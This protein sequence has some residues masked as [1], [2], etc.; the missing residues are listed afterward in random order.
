MFTDKCY[1][2]KRRASS[3][4][5]NATCCTMKS[6]WLG[7][8]GCMGKTHK[9][10][11][12]A[13]APVNLTRGL[14][15]TYICW[16]TFHSATQ[17]CT[18]GTC[19]HI[20]TLEN[21]KIARNHENDND[22]H[23]AHVPTYV[24]GIEPHPSIEAKVTNSLTVAHPCASALC[25]RTPLTSRQSNIEH[26]GQYQNRYARTHNVSAHLCRSNAYLL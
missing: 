1:W 5:P 16:C 23:I 8:P 9:S 7:I 24:P 15:R 13:D 20:H 11:A 22:V 4:L 6:V 25:R 3:V 2:R 19:Y 10:R 18:P 17:E 14:G 21:Q 26:D 12:W